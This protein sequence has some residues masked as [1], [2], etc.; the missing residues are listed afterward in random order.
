MNI[1][2]RSIIVGVGT[3]VGLKILVSSVWGPLL[4]SIILAA[5]ID[6]DINLFRGMIYGIII[7]LILTLFYIWQKNYEF[8]PFLNGIAGLALITVLSGAIGALFGRI[9]KGRGGYIW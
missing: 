7:G 8:G 1:N 4:L 5:K 2:Y 6:K 9:F 3:A